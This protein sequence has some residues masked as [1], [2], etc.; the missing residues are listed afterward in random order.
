[1][2]ETVPNLY[3]KKVE[4]MRKT[5]LYIAMSLDGYIADKNNNVDFLHG[6]IEGHDDV[7]GYDNF[8]KTVDTVIMG[9]K[10]YKKITTELSKDLWPYSNMQSYV[11]THRNP[12]NTETIKFIQTD[13]KELI[14]KLKNQD[15]KDIFVCGGADLIG[16][17][18]DNRLIDRFVISVIPTIIGGGL[19]LFKETINEQRLRLIGIEEK[20]SI[21]ELTYEPIS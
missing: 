13:L 8:S 21:V 12:K 10:T 20:N 2:A 15:G 5:V 7:A 19:R 14:T 17:L 4:F 1:M 18:M 3:E 11:L 6:E 16:Q 9:Y